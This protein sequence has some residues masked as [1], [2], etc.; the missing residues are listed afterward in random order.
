MDVLY[1]KCSIFGVLISLLIT[2]GCTNMNKKEVNSRDGVP[3]A[4]STYGSGK[5][6]IVLVHCW[7]CDQQ[8][9]K[10]QV[11]FFKDDFQVVTFD[12]AGHGN[13][14]TDRNEWT[15]PS[16]GDDVVAVLNELNAEKVYLV[17]HSMGGMVALDA[18]S[19]TD[20]I[21]RLILVDILTDKY[22][23]I[24][25]EEVRDFIQPF[26][27][28]FRGQTYEWA[29]NELF[30]PGTD[31]HLKDTIAT[32]M[33]KAPPE[34]ALPAMYDMLSRNY[35]QTMEEVNRNG[36]QIYAINSDRWE[37]DI[38]ELRKLGIQHTMIMHDVGHFPMLEAPE[39]FNQVLYTLITG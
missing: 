24:P 1:V 28:N 33:A 26:R 17:G 12:L 9:W 10:A 39:S 11:E 32:D 14:G 31:A 13:S 21:D 7:S 29:H 36:I 25:E 35:D 18:A 8:Y 38:E 34:I 6:A 5:D 3:I 23:P 2:T 27:D 16:F 37:T 15:I 30:V 22:W 4:Y 19:K 20:R